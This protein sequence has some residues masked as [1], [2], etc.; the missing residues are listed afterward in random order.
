MKKVLLTAAIAVISSAAVKAQSTITAATN[1]P[2]IGDTFIGHFADTAGVTPG[3]SGAS[4][5]WNFATLTQLGMDTTAYIA[6]DS[7]PYC[8]SFSGSNLVFSNAGDTI[9]AIATSSKISIIGAHSQGAPFHFSNPKDIMSFPLTYHTT[10]YD[11]AKTTISSD[12]GTLY[13]TFTDSSY[14]DAYGTLTLPGGTYTNALRVHTTTITKDSIY[15]PGFPSASSTW[16]E[17]YTWYKPGFRSPL[18]SLTYDTSN[19]P[20]ALSEVKYYTQKAGVNAVN[21]VNN[22]KAGLTLYP[23][24]ASEI[25]NIKFTLEN[26]ADARLSVFDLTGRT[27]ATIPGNKLNSGINNINV[28][29]SSL[30]DGIY[31]VQL[32]AAGV[33]VTQKLVVQK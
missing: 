15:I 8:D 22:N 2:A 6:C 16:S 27:V 32:Q 21:D 9:Y 24:P 14:C 10:F 33:N 25:I 28:P 7:T 4:A 11:T 1:T 19:G 3:A 20:V 12:F 31:L 29:V 13:L 5:T 17:T 26:A 23:N 18:L 30:P